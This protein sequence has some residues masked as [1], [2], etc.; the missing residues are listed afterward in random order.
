MPFQS[1]I[2]RYGLGRELQPLQI[3]LEAFRMNLLPFQF[4]LEAFE[5]SS[6]TD[7]AT[8]A[9]ARTPTGIFLPLPHTA[10]PSISAHTR[11]GRFL[12]DTPGGYIQNSL[13]RRSR[14]GRG[15][16]QTMKKLYLLE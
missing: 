8:E 13:H 14:V 6:P 10:P 15:I 2:S 5:N 16:K 11:G 7:T 1:E 4:E 9:N 12:Y 3:H